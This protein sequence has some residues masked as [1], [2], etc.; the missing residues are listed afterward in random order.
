MNSGARQGHRSRLALACAGVLAPLVVASHASAQD[1]DNAPIPSH[2]VRMFIDSGTHRASGGELQPVW[3]TIVQ[4]P[5]AEWLRLN[6]AIADLAFDRRTGQGSL[7]RVTSLE[8]GATQTLDA[9]TVR[10]WRNT[11]A[12][13]NGDAVSVE[14]LTGPAS[15]ASRV[16]IDE[17]TAGDPPVNADS[18]CGDTDDR[19]PSD[20]ARAARALPSGCTAW[21]IDDPA[22]CFLS[23]G[24][25][26]TLGGISVVEFNVPMSAS[27]GAIRHPPPEDQ[28]SVDLTSMQDRWTTIGDD[29]AYFG[30]YE[31]SE[32][33]LYAWQVQQDWF[34]LADP[35]AVSGQDIRITGYGTTSFPIDP[36]WNQIQKTHAGPY[37]ARL[38][39]RLEYRADTTGGNSG[40]PVIN[41]DT[42]EAIGVHTNAGCTRSGGANSGTGLNNTGVQA[43]LDNPRSVCAQMV[44]EVDA[45]FAGL[46][47]TM[48]TPNGTPGETVYFIYSLTG[49]GSTFVPSLNV[50]LDL[51]RPRLG[52]SAV[53][54]ASGLAELTSDPLPS[55]SALTVV[56]IQAAEFGRVSNVV[57]SQIN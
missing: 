40:S 15:G 28:Y 17:V 49:E 11:S 35:P 30:T 33:G 31:N 43:A 7:L 55:G 53:A 18:I 41:D 34:T 5:G 25:C 26:V 48:R 9:R 6:F 44:L 10:Q 20:D 45:L 23:A 54:D 32:T 56:W 47:A 36:Q 14:L 16:V 46:S 37:H 39:T 3:S 19:L 57:L 13:F 38:G 51:D 21:I 12:Y 2:P 29:W 1:L 22:H 50:T 4:E 42:G 24:H 8:D 27:N 52:G